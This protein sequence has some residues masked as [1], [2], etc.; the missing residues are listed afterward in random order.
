MSAFDDVSY[1]QFKQSAA[2]FFRA[3]KDGTASLDS[4]ENGHKALAIL[5]LNLSRECADWE[6]NSA[7][8]TLELAGKRLMAYEMR[9][10]HLNPPLSAFAE[11]R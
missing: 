4:V 3:T 9:E 10:D 7:V 6:I 8:I 1:D 5:Y 11:M 2:E